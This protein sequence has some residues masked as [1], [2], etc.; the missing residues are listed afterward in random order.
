MFF[1]CPI[2]VDPMVK[3]ASLSSVRAGMAQKSIKTFFL[4]GKGHESGDCKEDQNEKKYATALK[5]IEQENASEAKQPRM[6]R[7]AQNR[8]TRVTEV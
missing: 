7:N 1:S 6:D 5:Q 4:K 8:V 2:T 3:A